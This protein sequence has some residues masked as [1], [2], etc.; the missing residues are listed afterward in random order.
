MKLK[1]NDKESLMGLYV[2]QQCAKLT[3]EELLKVH[4]NLIVVLNR[5]NLSGRKERLA[6]EYLDIVISI[7]TLRNLI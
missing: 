2:K 4:D 5:E 3:D 1:R 6:K 7:M